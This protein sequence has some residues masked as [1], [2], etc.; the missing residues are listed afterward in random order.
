MCQMQAGRGGGGEG[1]II[2][3]RHLFYPISILCVDTDNLHMQ[4]N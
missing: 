4:G 2:G 3:K 1:M